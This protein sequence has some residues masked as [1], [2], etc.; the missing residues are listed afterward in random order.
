[1]DRKIDVIFEP[2]L[3][4]GRGIPVRWRIKPARRGASRN[5]NGAFDLRAPEVTNRKLATKK[6]TPPHPVTPSEQAAAACL[7]VLQ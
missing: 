4:P 6:R 1:M 5:G 3:A 7:E 2:D